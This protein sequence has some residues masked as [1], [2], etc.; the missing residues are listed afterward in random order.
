MTLSASQGFEV[1]NKLL[2]CFLLPVYFPKWNYL[3]IYLKMVYQLL[4][5]SSANEKGQRD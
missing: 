1:C 4:C 5:L 2:G 3:L